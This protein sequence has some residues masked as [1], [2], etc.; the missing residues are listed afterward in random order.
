MK[1][2]YNDPLLTHVLSIATYFGISNEDLKWYVYVVDD[3]VRLVIDGRKPCRRFE[4][5]VMMEEWSADIRCN[6]KDELTNVNFWYSHG[7]PAHRTYSP[8]EV[9]EEVRGVIR[10]FCRYVKTTQMSVNQDHVWDRLHQYAGHSGA[11]PLVTSYGWIERD[12]YMILTLHTDSGETLTTHYDKG[13]GKPVHKQLEVVGRSR[14]LLSYVKPHHQLTKEDTRGAKEVYLDYLNVKMLDT[15]TQIS[16]CFQLGEVVNWS[17]DRYQEEG[18]VLL[19]INCKGSDNLV[20]CYDTETRKPCYIKPTMK[21]R[22][23]LPST[24]E[25]DD[26][27]TAS[28][29]EYETYS[30]IFSS[31]YDTFIANEHLF[32]NMGDDT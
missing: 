3:R 28:N 9:S 23:G 31:A 19:H 8:D 22:C 21:H 32:N 27:V 12:G 30:L 7:D 17:W 15:L 6:D 20:I 24:K 13:T 1:M 11:L 25:C 16:K 29:A 5:D 10:T 14:P 26:W 4:G 18:V 2:N